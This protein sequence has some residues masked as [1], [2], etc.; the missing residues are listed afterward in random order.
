MEWARALIRT[1]I[2]EGS[3]GRILSSWSL[4]GVALLQ[5][6][7]EVLEAAPVCGEAPAAW[8]VSH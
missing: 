5:G 3:A 6:R 8:W 1:F 2:G 4:D 7:V